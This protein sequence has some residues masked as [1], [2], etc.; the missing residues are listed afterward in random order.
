MVNSILLSISGKRSLT[1]SRPFA[2]IFSVTASISPWSV[3]IWIASL[4]G[5]R[6]ALRTGL[7]PFGFGRW[8]TRPP[9]PSLAAIHWSV[10]W[11]TGVYRTHRYMLQR[12]SLNVQRGVSFLRTCPK[13]M[14]FRCK[15]F[16]NLSRQRRRKTGNGEIQGSLHC[17]GKSAAF[18][19]DDIVLVVG[20]S[21]TG[22]CKRTFTVI[23]RQ[24]LR[25]FSS[26]SD[27]P[28]SPQPRPERGDGS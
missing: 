2:D 3:Q 12:F 8:L 22:N 9:S 13:T 27:S 19:R 28:P 14:E 16:I 6:T 10:D 4:I 11:H 1:K 21:R 24:V 15:G 23:L 20:L 5:K 7:S 17:D 25:R 18:G 26:R